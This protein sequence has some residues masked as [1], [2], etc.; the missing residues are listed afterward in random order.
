MSDNTWTSEGDKILLNVEMNGGLQDVIIKL[1]KI[2]GVKGEKWDF[3]GKPNLYVF[4]QIKVIK[5]QKEGILEILNKEGFLHYHKG[6][7]NK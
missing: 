6:F 1:N 7:N 3:V 2:V 5:S 4:P